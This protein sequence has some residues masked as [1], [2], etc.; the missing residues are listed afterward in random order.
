MLLASKRYI[1]LGR[2]D[3]DAEGQDRMLD[4]VV[5]G[6]GRSGTTALA[7]SFNLHANIFC[8]IEQLPLSAD[9]TS[10]IMPQAML[11]S[12]E[13]TERWYS[14][15]QRELLVKKLESTRS[16]IYG[17]KNPFYQY[18]LGQIQKSSRE[19]K[20]VYIYRNPEQFVYS[21]DERSRSGKDG[22]SR[23]MQGIFGAVE[24]IYC[25]KRILQVDRPVILTSFQSLFFEDET[26]M[27]RLVDELGAAPDETFQRAF[28]KNLFRKAKQR[29]KATSYY[30]S[31]FAQYPF[32]LISAYFTSKP[33]SKSDS[34]AFADAVEEQFNK[35]PAPPVFAEFVRQL[36][37][38]AVSFGTSWASRC[39]F[40]LD[41]TDDAANRW[42]A[43]YAGEVS[44]ILRKIE[45]PLGRRS[46]SFL[47]RLARQIQ[48][49]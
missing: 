34:S 33:L 37:R 11:V 24:Q 2:G 35:L 42:L 5:I 25:L 43:N 47:R 40:L 9:P 46:F 48:K 18:K 23:G 10:F 38:H 27:N 49:I 17:D 8:G 45:A 22:W 4:F 36:D 30:R 32:A 31:F 1:V 12:Y 39:N 41:K 44:D 21:W 26:L 7:R 20:L 6:P 19:I 15:R 29:T 14:A 28:S 16:M 3:L 13:D